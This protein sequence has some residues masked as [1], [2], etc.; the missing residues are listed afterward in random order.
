MERCHVFNNIAHHALGIITLGGPFDQR[1]GPYNDVTIRN[2]YIYNNGP[3]WGGALYVMDRQVLRVINSTM[4]GNTAWH[5]F[6]NAGLITLGARY[7]ATMT[8]DCCIYD[9]AVSLKRAG[10]LTEYCWTPPPPP[11]PS[12]PPPPPPTSPPT[13]VFPGVGTLQAAFDNAAAGDELLLH[14]GAS[15]SR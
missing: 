8:F 4:I 3:C 10:S 6:G 2:S 15:P 14:D 7:Y 11:L 12:L 9:G 1:G 5:S 13:L